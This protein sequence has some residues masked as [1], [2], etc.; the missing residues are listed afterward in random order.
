MKKM[1]GSLNKPT[2]AAL[3]SVAALSLC[4]LLPLRVY[5]AATLIEPKTGFFAEN[6]WSVWVFY[7]L[8]AAVVA[9]LAVAS[10][11]NSKANRARDC[12]AKN[13]VLGIV[14][15]VTGAAV[16]CDA[17]YEMMLFLDLYG[18]YE[19]CGISMASYLTKNGGTALL[20][21]AIFAALSA[22]F[23]WVYSV[24]CFSR[25]INMASFR[26]LSVA[27]VAWSICRIIYRFVTKISFVNVSDLLLELF[28]LVFVI[29]FTLAFA[30]IVTNVSPEVCAWRLFGC[31]LPAALLA[32]LVSVP[33]LILLVIGHADL[34]VA[35]H[36]FAPCDLMLSVFIP[37]FLYFTSTTV[38]KKKLKK[39][40]KQE[41][42]E[43]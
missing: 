20:F 28:M 18:S 38:K 4:V 33:R 2:P 30:Q 11:M 41:S 5:Q 19:P 40:E 43:V 24:F 36:G 37:V 34:I 27:P 29:S 39:Q 1:K 23:F 10:F 8:C 16:I 42:T 32:F 35:G 21:G 12:M 7:I 14:S 31:G 26:V 15:L 17:A 9:F 22:A 6:N 25:T 3:I 13:T